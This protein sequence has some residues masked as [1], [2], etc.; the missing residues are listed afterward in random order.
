M[1][2]KLDVRQMRLLL[3]LLD[4]KSIS[5]VAESLNVSQQAVSIQLKIL[6][7][8]FQDTLFVRHGHGVAPTPKAIKLGLMLKDIVKALEDSVQPEEFNAKNINKTIVIS[9]TDYAQ[10]VITTALFSHIRRVAPGIKLIITELEIETLTQSLTAG[11]VDLA[12]TIPEFLSDNLPCE[13]LFNEQY[14]L[15]SSAANAPIA[16]AHITDL[17]QYEHVIVSPSRPNLRGSSTDWFKRHHV[18]RNIVASIPSFTMLCE[19]VY[20]SD[21]IAFIPSRMLPDSRLRAIK[22]TQYPPGFDAVV[23]WHPKVTH[24]PLYKWLITQIK[25]IAESKSI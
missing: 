13:T 6:R 8:I 21:V 3:L 12:I 10:Q 4:K 11:D 22:L 19:Y 2:E 5:R 20:K 24:D 25:Q 23:A 1:L 17:N 15:V 9:A 14:K 16:L 18:N 7:D